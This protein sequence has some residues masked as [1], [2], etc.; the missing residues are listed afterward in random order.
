VHGRALRVSCS[1][2]DDP[3]RLAAPLGLARQTLHFYVIRADTPEKRARE[4]V[5]RGE[6]SEGGE[7]AGGGRGGRGRT[8][9][10]E[11]LIRTRRSRGR[12]AFRYVPDRLIIAY[13]A[14]RR[15]RG[16]TPPP[17]GPNRIARVIL[18][19]P[20]FQPSARA[21]NPL[22]RADSIFILPK[23]GKHNII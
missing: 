12:R 4:A 3:V 15:K 13:P 16:P 14:G 18:F 5:R 8:V 21:L 7:E 22:S 1:Y 6:R 2:L 9:R 10:G 23:C 19:P 20:I 11:S 17:R